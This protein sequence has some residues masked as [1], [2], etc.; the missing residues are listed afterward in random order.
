MPVDRDYIDKLIRR[1]H[2]VV[3][4]DDYPKYFTDGLRYLVAC[5]TTKDNC[6]E[7]M[8]T[9]MYRQG[10]NFPPGRMESFYDEIIERM[11]NAGESTT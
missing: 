9:W 7:L 11:K 2:V 6:L 1:N 4:L 3:K 5:G 8:Y 10:Y